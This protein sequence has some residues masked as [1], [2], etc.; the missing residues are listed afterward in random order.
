MKNAHPDDNLKYGDRISEIVS[1][2]DYV[3]INQKDNSIE[4]VKEYYINGDFVKLDVRATTG[5]TFFARSLYTLNRGRVDRFVAHGT[6][7]PLT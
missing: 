4:F 2:P 5:G 1:S 7:V 6:L 3:G